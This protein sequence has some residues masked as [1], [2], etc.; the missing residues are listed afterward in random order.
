MALLGFGSLLVAMTLACAMGKTSGEDEPADSGD[1]FASRRRAMVATQIES[2]GV[3]NP[4]VL[5][6]MRKDDS[7]LVMA[8]CLS[9]RYKEELKKEIPEITSVQEVR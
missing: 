9:E 3:S 1:P 8:G 2:R 7:V 5:D 6:A 4:E